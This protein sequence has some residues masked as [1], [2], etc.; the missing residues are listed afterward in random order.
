M[1]MEHAR[2]CRIQKLKYEISTNANPTASDSVAGNGTH[3]DGDSVTVMA[4]TNSHYQFQK[5][6]K[7]VVG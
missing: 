6:Q 2:I 1:R 3:S 4:A 7:M 5:W